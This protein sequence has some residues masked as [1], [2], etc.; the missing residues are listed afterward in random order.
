MAF[1]SS[2]H[3]IEYPKNAPLIEALIQLHKDMKHAEDNARDNIAI[4]LGEQSAVTKKTDDFHDVKTTL[5]TKLSNAYSYVLLAAALSGTARACIPAVG[6]VIALE[7]FAIAVLRPGTA[8]VLVLVPARAP[9]L[10]AVAGIDAAIAGAFFF[11]VVTL[12]SAV[13]ILVAV[14]KIRHT[15][16]FHSFGRVIHALWR[17]ARPRPHETVPAA[18]YAA[19]SDRGTRTGLQTRS[20]PDSLPDS[21]SWAQGAWHDC[22]ARGGAHHARMNVRSGL[23]GRS[24]ERQP[25]RTALP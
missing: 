21:G 16:P 4:S 11:P 25:Q 12:L 9:A 8:S 23:D 24:F 1:G 18:A 13:L 7:V 3:A 5:N 15:L 10:I 20:L 14:L 19:R 2:C 22:S 6:A 17:S